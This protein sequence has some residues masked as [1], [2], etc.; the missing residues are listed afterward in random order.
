MVNPR[1][2]KK[3]ALK[4]R[5]RNAQT[6]SRLFS[7]ELKMWPGN[8][9]IAASVVSFSAFYAGGRGF[10]SRIRQSYRSALRA[11]TIQSSSVDSAE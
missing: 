9:K 6:S 11:L 3:Y 5:I 4:N 8:F 1:L 2:F 7:Y 10:D